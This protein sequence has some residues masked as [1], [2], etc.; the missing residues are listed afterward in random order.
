MYGTIWGFLATFQSEAT[1]HI[2]S[3]HPAFSSLPNLTLSQSLPI[4]DMTGNLIFH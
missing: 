1:A 4:C 2:K 3:F